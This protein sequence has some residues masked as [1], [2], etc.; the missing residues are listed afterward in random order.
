MQLWG[1]DGLRGKVH[2]LGLLWSFKDRHQ[3]GRGAR[4]GW[5]QSLLDTLASFVESSVMVR[6]RKP[7]SQRVTLWCQQPSLPSVPGSDPVQ[8]NPAMPWASSM[9]GAC[10][11]HLQPA[12]LTWGGGSCPGHTDVSRNRFS[13]CPGHCDAQKWNSRIV[14]PAD[15]ST[16]AVLSEDR[17][18]A[19]LALTWVCSCTEPLG[20]AQVSPPA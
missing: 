3:P 8:A 10:V 4:L 19:L 7:R 18:C 2:C 20:M 14:A 5:Q 6:H 11:C 15:P 17:V 16:A 9:P 12:G 1:C 13:C